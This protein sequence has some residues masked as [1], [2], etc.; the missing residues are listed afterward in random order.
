VL[1]LILQN[2]DYICHRVSILSFRVKKTNVWGLVSDVGWESR[3]R[4]PNR[5]LLPC[6]SSLQGTSGQQTLT[7]DL[8][9]PSKFA[10][11]SLLGL[12]GRRKT[13]R[14]ALEIGNFH[15]MSLAFADD[16]MGFGIPSASHGIPKIW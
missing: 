1:E 16:F 12:P 8:I 7:A 6:C 9:Q 11:L 3:K 5:R 2:W 13:N 15:L 14:A 10:A 4:L